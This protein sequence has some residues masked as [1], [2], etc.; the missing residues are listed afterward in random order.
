MNIHSRRIATLA[1]LLGA[2][3]MSACTNPV[4][5]EQVA[6]QRASIINGD[7]VQADSLGVVLIQTGRH[8]CTGALMTS[9]WVLTAGHCVNDVS[10]SDVDVQHTASVGGTFETTG[11]GIILA[12][13]A[14]VALVRLKDPVT[15][16]G[17]R[18][19]Q[20]RTLLLGSAA[21][22]RGT[23]LTCY[24]Y[25]DDG[26]QSPI[27][28][29]RKAS[30]LVSA[31]TDG[32]ITL[33]TTQGQAV[34]LGDSGGPCFYQ[35]GSYLYLAGVIHNIEDDK[36]PARVANTNSIR[37]W[38]DYYMAFDDESLGGQF[39]SGGAIASYGPNTLDLFGRGTDNGLWEKQWTGSGWTGW[40]N[41]H[42]SITADPAA[43]YVSPSS[44]IA[45]VRGSAHNVISG[46]SSSKTWPSADTWSSVGGNITTNPS[47]V[48]TGDGNI[49]L[50][51]R[52][53]DN[54]LWY[55]K[56]NNVGNWSGWASLGGYVGSDIAA[57]SAN[58][59][60][61][62]VFY[63][64]ADSTIEHRY[65]TA[66]GWSG[67]SSIDGTKFHWAPAATSSAGGRIDLFE[68]N[69]DATIAHR[70]WYG[71]WAETWNNLGY[72]TTSNLA[73]TSWFPGRIDGIFRGPNNEMRHFFWG[74]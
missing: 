20:N 43:V 54:A 36:G 69:D 34:A 10:A 68:I 13:N 32:Y 25:G 3:L 7:T 46:S 64:A 2:L 60:E 33:S 73:V 31:V 18:L 5:Q 38:V 29:L 16:Q 71:K 41:L 48:N 26:H 58:S 21:A 17:Q 49:W 6:E 66:S 30:L 22:L 53:T 28:I 63:L 65:Y 59:G 19:R 11:T 35:Q 15:V 57:V 67:A 40:R 1:H 56:Q 55:R 45:F 50:F 70:I 12:D 37:D 23:T 9:A 27:G 4:D 44:V 51:G 52:G 8:T 42:G 62:D 47:T 24:G 39:T 14:D 74:D 61:I 72:S